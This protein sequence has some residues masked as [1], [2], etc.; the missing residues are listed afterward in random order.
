MSTFRFENIEVWKFGIEVTIKLLDIAE[1]L[2]TKR[3]SSFS[4]QL[5]DASLSITNNI[6]EGSGS[7]S[8]KEFTVFLNY[9]RRSVFE[10]ANIIF[11]LSFK[12]Y[13]SEEMKSQRLKELDLLSRRITTFRRSLQK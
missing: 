1:F 10:C 12:N 11:V 7:F 9:S 5:R 8:E 6:A 2:D 4:N 3:L 13:I